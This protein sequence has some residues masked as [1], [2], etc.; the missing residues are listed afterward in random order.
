MKKI[1]LLGAATIYGL[2]SSD[3]VELFFFTVS[4]TLEQ[5]RW[6]GG[7]PCGYAKTL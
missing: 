1:G 3:D 6:G 2:G 5:G 4:K 7:V